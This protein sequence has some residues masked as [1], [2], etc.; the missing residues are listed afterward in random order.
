MTIT[1]EQAKQMTAKERAAIRELEKD[2][3]ISI[4]EYFGRGERRAIYSLRNSVSGRIRNEI[5]RMYGRYGWRVQ[6]Q[7]DQR[8]GDWLEFTPKRTERAREY[9]MSR[10]PS[11][12]RGSGIFDQMEEIFG[13]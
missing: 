1:P 9:R 6:Y 3:D 4:R 10:E 8:D 13:R 5:K 2:I 12:P 7:S 11:V